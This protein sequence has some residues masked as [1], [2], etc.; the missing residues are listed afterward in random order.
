[1]RTRDDTLNVHLLGGFSVEFGFD[2]M[3]PLP[4]RVGRLLASY[5]LLRAGRPQ[6]R[7]VLV[8]VFWPDVEESRGRRRLSH[9]LW[10]LQDALAEVAPGR[11]YVQTPGDA[12]LFGG[13][14]PYW[15]DVQ[16]FETRLDRVDAGARVDA[17][18]ERELRRC[19]E[20]YRGDLL[21]GHYEPWVIDEQQRL[22]HRYLTALTRLV[23]ACKQ[24][25]NFDDAL[26]FARRVTHQ[27]PLR[28]D[29]HREVMRLCVLLGQPSLAMEQFERCRSVLLEELGA[30]PDAETMQLHERVRTTRARSTPARDRPRELVSQRLVG[31]DAERTRL[32][33][34]LDRALGSRGGAA[35]V[36]GEPGVGKSHLLAQLADDARWRGFTVLWGACSET[37]TGSAYAP[38]RDALEP[39]LQPVRVTQLRHNLPAVWMQEAATLLPALGAPDA[40]S[41]PVHDPERASRMREALVHLITELA[42]LTPTLVILEDLQWADEETLGLLEHWARR[43]PQGRL[44]LV[45]TCRDDEARSRPPVWEALRSVDRDA[46]PERI[47]LAPLTAFETNDLV[48]ELLDLAEVPTAFVTDVHRESGGNPLYVLEILR[49]R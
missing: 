5:L 30:E 44:L 43:R 33:A 49:A 22:E 29:G 46:R 14:D 27:S 21:A 2:P 45:L 11:A 6:P 35:L 42:A 10:Q 40:P 28:E 37:T 19:V 48:A 17:A 25:G 32:L 3:P 18:A 8:D 34:L 4:S 24:Q 16:E 13:P 36:E 9:V 7:S 47:G 20:L 39:E 41:S 31:R 1:M 12:V 15:L 38:V 23:E 26:T